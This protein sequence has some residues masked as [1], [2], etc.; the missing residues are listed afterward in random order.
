[1]SLLRKLRALDDR[2]ATASPVKAG[3]LRERRADE[4]VEDHLRYIASNG[5]FGTARVASDVLV[6]LDRM[7]A[8]E[9]RVE[10]LEQ[11]E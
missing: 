9:R 4:P 6:V 1:M 10:A 8:L 5:G 7:V 2:A 11:R 3:L